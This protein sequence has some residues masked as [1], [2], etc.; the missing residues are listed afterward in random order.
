MSANSNRPGPKSWE[1]LRFAVIGPLLSSPP[2]HGELKAELIRLSQ[3]LWL[4]PITGELSQF[5]FSTIENWL[6]RARKKSNDP[7]GALKREVRSDCG[8]ISINPKLQEALQA[9]HKDHPTWS[10]MLHRD[11]LV[12]LVEKEADL[13]PMPSYSTICRLMKAKG[14]TKKKKKKWQENR[15]EV[16]WKDVE[17]RSY[18]T[19]YVGSLWHF[20][21]HHASR[22][23]L[24]PNGEWARSRTLQVQVQN[25]KS[26]DLSEFMKPGKRVVM[27]PGEYKSGELIYPFPGWQ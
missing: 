20:D 4:H 25:V 27:Y 6:Y 21:F 19:E 26:R 17:V 1:Q 5:K 12:A 23:I 22:T 13:G 14:M 24:A 7:V 16:I 9:Q 18:E 2:K 11:N 8:K 10:Y 3:K 15:V